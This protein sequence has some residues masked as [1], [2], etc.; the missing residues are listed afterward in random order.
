M[1]MVEFVMQMC[2]KLVLSLTILL[3][4]VNDIISLFKIRT[5]R[6]AKL[7]LLPKE[8]LLAMPVKSLDDSLG[9]EGLVPSAL[10]FGENPQIR[11]PRLGNLT[12]PDLAQRA[13]AAE[14]ARKEMSFQMAKLRFDGALQDKVPDSALLAY[15][16]GAQVLI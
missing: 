10:I 12:R 5:K 11:A 8:I 4:L 13:N 7:T 16:P 14:E 9:P 15:E 3:D 1:F 2:P 6:S